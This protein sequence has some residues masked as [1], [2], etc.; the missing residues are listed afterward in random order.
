MHHSWLYCGLL[1]AA[2]GS[3]IIIGFSGYIYL[4]L[5]LSN[6]LNNIWYIDEEPVVAIGLFFLA[7]TIILTVICHG[8][9]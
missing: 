1:A 9:N 5:K 3:G 2:I 7:I 4:L 8:G 6:W